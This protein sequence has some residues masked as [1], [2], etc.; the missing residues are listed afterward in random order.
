MSTVRINTNN[1][2]GQTANI[3][4]T[5]DTGGTITI[6]SYVLPYDAI[7]NYYYGNYNLYFPLFDKTCVF[8]IVDHYL[9]QEDGFFILQ[10]DNSYIIIT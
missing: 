7:L 3:T 9:L 8:S 1:Y 6:G 10:E 2:S 5:S 4:F